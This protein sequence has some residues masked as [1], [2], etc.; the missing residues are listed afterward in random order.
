MSQFIETIK[1][2]N[3]V[4][5][6]IHYHNERFKRTLKDFYNLRSNPDLGKIL[7]S[8]KHHAGTGLVKATIEYGKE[9]HEIRF[10]QYH[11]KKIKSLR[12]IEG[13]LEYSYKYA[14]RSGLNELLGRRGNFDEIIIC[15]DGCLTDSSYSNL[16]FS[17]GNQWFTPLHPLLKGTC[18][19]RLI[20]EKKITEIPVKTKDLK[21]F[22]LCSLIN[23]M[24]DL[25][26]LYV[27]VKNISI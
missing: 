23:A 19:Q 5:Q 1:I 2:L 27:E 12:L 21:N 8:K 7:Q 4:P 9:I 20:E 22:Q 25:G 18:R 26:E 24:L 15:R 14:N 17:D 11:T 13:D 16:A 6:H 10:Q 3:G